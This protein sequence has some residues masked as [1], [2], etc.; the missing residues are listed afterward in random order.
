MLHCSI[1]FYVSATVEEVGALPPLY[2]IP[3]EEF[4]SLSSQTAS[5]TFLFL[6]LFPLG[7]S[8]VFVQCFI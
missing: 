3:S 4:H 7:G 1:C 8:L 6:S 2:D 5:F